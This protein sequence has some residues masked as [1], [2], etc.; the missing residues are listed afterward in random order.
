MSSALPGGARPEDLT[1]P[2]KIRSA[3]IAHLARDGFQKANLR[4][5]AADAGVSAGLIFHH[6]GSKKGLLTACDERVLGVLTERART[7]GRASGSGLHDL[8]RAYVSDPE[9]Y[10][11]HVQYMARAIAEDTPAAERFVATLVEESE[12]I[13]RAGAADGS[14]RESS[15]PRALAVLNVLISQ[16]LLT[17]PPPLARALGAER[18]GPEVLARMAVPALE[19]FT[20]GLY[21][22]DTLLEAARDAWASAR[23]ASSRKTED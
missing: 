10:R 3:A 1:A 23:P 18:L 4:A 6:F 16:A 5:I 19:L 11:V 12:E 20:R 22:D 9:D 2:A 14:M 15:D 17:M 21:T 13:F 8:H 7:A